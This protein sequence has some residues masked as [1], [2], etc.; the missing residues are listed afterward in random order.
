MW[1]RQPA[2]V[3]SVIGFQCAL[4]A[5]W[6]HSQLYLELSTCDQIIV[7]LLPGMNRDIEL[8]EFP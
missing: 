2:N 8:P 6:V 7:M 3:N 1:P 4:N 5:S